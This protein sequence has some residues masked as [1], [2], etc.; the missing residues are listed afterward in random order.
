MPI[1]MQRDTMLLVLLSTEL[2]F[3]A[4]AYPDG[5]STIAEQT[6]PPTRTPASPAADK[7]DAASA[8]IPGFFRLGFSIFQGRRRVPARPTRFA[9]RRLALPFLSSLH[10]RRRTNSERGWGESGEIFSAGFG[11]E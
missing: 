4:M 2:P 5:G 1:T 9:V 8:E 7:S 10:R 3:R 11:R 6:P